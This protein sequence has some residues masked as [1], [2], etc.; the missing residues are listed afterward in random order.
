MTKSGR[1]TLSIKLLIVIIGGLAF[2]TVIFF[3][4][5]YI[6]SSYLQNVYLSDEHTKERND[7][8]IENFSEYVRDN[9]VESSD[10]KSIL[11]WQESENNVYILVYENDK[12]IYDST[13]WGNR[14]N[15]NF[16]DKFAITDKKTGDVVI[17]ETEK[18]EILRQI[19]L[20]REEDDSDT[21]GTAATTEE[22]TEATT[23]A[24]TQ[25]IA[26]ASESKNK[27]YNTYNK[28]DAK[29]DGNK[30]PKYY[31]VTEDS[32]TNETQTYGFYPV[33]FADGVYDVCILDYSESKVYGYTL[34]IAFFFSSLLLVIIIVIYH[35]RE[36]KRI[37][38]L[39]NEVK[40]IES[41]DIDNP[42]SLK[43]RDEIYD[44]SVSVDNMRTRIIDN[45]SKE[46]EAWQA[47][48]D[49]V[50]AMAHDIR[51]PL[52]VL[53]GYLDLIKNKD[54]SSEEELLQYIDISVDKAEQLRD[55]SDK[56]FRYFYVYSKSDENLVLEEFEVSALF[57]QL[58]GE[59]V[60]LLEDKG[61]HFK[62]DT[63]SQSV[64][65]KVDVQYLKRLTDNIFTNIRKYADKS[66]PVKITQSIHRD[67]LFIRVRNE[68]SKERN[69]AESTRIGIQ[70]CEKIAEQ[71][72][73]SFR[74][75]E[76]GTVFTVYIEFPVLK[77]NKKENISE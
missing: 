71:M 5:V 68:I 61:F 57:D 53:A 56:L 22:A 44:L 69:T 64:N 32:E 11:K 26:E 58:V 62:I 8:H 29:N 39:T 38:R 43:G 60:I 41:I 73:G 27:P 7:A 12:I 14:R 10:I 72:N 37:I 24:T 36:I 54:Y 67:K 35:R 13:W 59:Y 19:K 16:M 75:E 2:A 76:R 70:T 4:N 42:I 48:S 33:R 15:R 49:L 3:L 6:I 1:L 46:K 18:K 9:K 28:S 34:V 51:T 31:V 47:N 50:T 25:E 17:S 74:T 52:T 65:I 77:N 63:L 40:D 21:D 66:K 55:L 30:T 45:M 20:K 23:A